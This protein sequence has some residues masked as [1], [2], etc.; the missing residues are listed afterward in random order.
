MIKKH[1]GVEL[2]RIRQSAVPTVRTIIIEEPLFRIADVCLFFV[3]VF[4]DFWYCRAGSGGGGPRSG[5]PRP[6]PPKCTSVCFFVPAF[7]PFSC[8]SSNLDDNKGQF[9][10]PSTRRDP[11]TTFKC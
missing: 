1:E 4:C 2:I 3:F 11:K 7:F 10:F 5:T 9:G 6:L 8:V